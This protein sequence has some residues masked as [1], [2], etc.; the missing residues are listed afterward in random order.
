MPVDSPGTEHRIEHG[1]DLG[2]EARTRDVRVVVSPADNHR[3]QMLDQRALFRM[4]MAMDNCAQ[5]LHMPADGFLDLS[6][7]AP[8]IHTTAMDRG[9]GSLV[10]TIF[11][12]KE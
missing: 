6:E 1:V 4:T 10:T 12:V 8:K 2:E 9:F 5:V 11:C 7:L 3:I